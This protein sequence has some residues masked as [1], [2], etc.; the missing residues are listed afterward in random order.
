MSGFSCAKGDYGDYLLLDPSNNYQSMMGEV[1]GTKSGQDTSADQEES[2]VLL[3]HNP[4]LCGFAAGAGLSPDT[5]DFLINSGLFY[6]KDKGQPNGDDKVKLSDLDNVMGQISDLT[7]GYVAGDQVQKAIVM[8]LME[9]GAEKTVTEGV[10]GAIDKVGWVALG[11]TVCADLQ[12]DAYAN[13]YRSLCYSED[14]TFTIYTLQGVGQISD[15]LNHPTILGYPID[16]GLF[17]YGKLI[18]LLAGFD[19]P[20]FIVKPNSIKNTSPPYAIANLRTFVPGGVGS[21]PKV[22]SIFSSYEIDKADGGLVSTEVNSNNPSEE[23]YPV[24]LNACPNSNPDYTIG[25]PVSS[26]FPIIANLTSYEQ[27]ISDSI[28]VK[29]GE[30]YSI[31]FYLEDK[32]GFSG[33]CPD[34]YRTYY[35][36]GALTTNARG[37]AHH[38]IV[39]S[40][41]EPNGYQLENPS[42]TTPEPTAS[43]D[44]GIAGGVDAS[45]KD[46]GVSGANAVEVGAALYC[47]GVTGFSCEFGSPQNALNAGHLTFS[48]DFSQ[49]NNQS[50]NITVVCNSTG[51]KLLDGAILSIFQEGYTWILNTDNSSST[52][53]LIITYLAA[54]GDFSFIVT[55]PDPTYG[56]CDSSD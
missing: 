27:A 41:T 16:K 35:K 49:D 52:S 20:V 12:S 23:P 53:T 38:D 32:S 39:V 37:G 15:W 11:L 34:G 13:Y 21:S 28:A 1:T 45:S 3:P 9:N 22:E 51:T 10:S 2:N 36:S 5:L 48:T 50:G 42:E 31:D 26:I 25:A 30:D 24:V 46:A 47:P 29:D 14:D 17:G 8:L 54:N 33:N 55:W 43:N 44:G 56:I 4:E 19:S 18:S 7:K 6:I 40:C